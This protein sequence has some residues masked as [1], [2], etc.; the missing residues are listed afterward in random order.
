MARLFV[1]SCIGKSSRGLRTA[2]DKLNP[3]T[4]SNLEKELIAT[5]IGN[6]TAILI[7]YAPATFQNALSYY[8]KVE[9]ETAIAK[10][11]QQVAP[12]LLHIYKQIRTMEECSEGV[13]IAFIA[14]IA[15]AAMEPEKLMLS[16]EIQRV[17]NDF[18]VTRGG[19]DVD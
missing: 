8:K 3:E 5:G 6:D 16:S 11:I 12:V 4:K 19:Y 1:M 10:T 9:P 14:D 7:Y 15:K 2:F 18:I 13:V 17:G